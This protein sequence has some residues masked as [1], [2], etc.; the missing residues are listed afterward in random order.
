MPSKILIAEDEK[1]M[2]RALVLKLTKEG[3]DAQSAGD[4]EEALQIL[5]KGGIDLMLLDL[6]MP[7]LDGFGVLK[8]VKERK[9]KVKIIVS[10]NLSQTEDFNKAKELG[11]L[12]FMVKS[13]VSLSE[14][15]EKVK[16]Y[17]NE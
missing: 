6:V 15:V 4:G 2:A 1:P 8:A 13:N 12:D 5:E 11:A 17:L 7:K 16:K 3:F 14:I 9:I 10:S